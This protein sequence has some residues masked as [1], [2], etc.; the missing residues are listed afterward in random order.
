MAAPASHP[1][2]RS[3]SRAT[4]QQSFI[5]DLPLGGLS[6]PNNEYHKTESEMNLLQNDHKE[7]NG[8]LHHLQ[9][10][11]S[12]VLGADSFQEL[13]G[14]T[15]LFTDPVDDVEEEDAEKEEDKK[16]RKKTR[17]TNSGS[18]SGSSSESSSGSSSATELKRRQFHANSNVGVGMKL[19][20][21][22]KEDDASKIYSAIIKE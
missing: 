16:Q 2:P 7:L 12:D 17:K 4:R 14:A 3:L 22:I 10:G 1:F 11:I 9:R 20:V 13:L 21:R 5:T 8:R 6:G 18:S 19:T 15:P